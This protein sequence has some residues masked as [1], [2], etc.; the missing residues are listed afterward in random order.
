MGRGLTED[1]IGAAIEVHRHLGPGLLESTYEEC[2]CRELQLR[3]LP[4]RR[5]VPLSLEYKG[6][7]LEDKH[8]IDLIVGEQ[9]VVELKAVEMLLPVHGAQLLSYM[10]LGGWPLGLLINF[11]AALVKSGMEQR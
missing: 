3:K 5:Q 11:H 8:R 7:R 9:V 6:L 10:R 1:V 2:L 4:F